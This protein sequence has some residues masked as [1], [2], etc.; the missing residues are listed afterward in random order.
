MISTAI[1]A[2]FS[3]GRYPCYIAPDGRTRRYLG[4]SH[5]TAKE[6]I[7]HTVPQYVSPLRAS[8]PSAPVTPLA[9]DSSSDVDGAALAPEPRTQRGSRPTGQGRL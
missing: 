7:A 3:E 8:G 5:K 2:S 9:S 4:C 1:Y 6:A